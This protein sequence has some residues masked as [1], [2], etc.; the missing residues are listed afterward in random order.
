[1]YLV[2]HG[3]LFVRQVSL[4]IISLPT[5]V[6]QIKFD[7]VKVERDSKIIQLAGGFIEFTKNK[8]VIIKL[9]AIDNGRQYDLEIN[10]TYKY[11][12]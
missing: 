11:N 6:G 5:D 1:M 3:G 12:N 7:K 4:F 8:R 2:G 9:V 10:G